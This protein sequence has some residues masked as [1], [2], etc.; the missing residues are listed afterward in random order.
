[1]SGL[2]TPVGDGWREGIVTISQKS[3]SR[4][5]CFH[6]LNSASVRPAT[7]VSEVLDEV[8][9]LLRLKFF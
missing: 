9:V 5:L 3:N 4:L 2:W 1:M 6:D 7:S 8:E